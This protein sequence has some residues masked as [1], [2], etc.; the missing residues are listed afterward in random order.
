MTHT[1]DTVYT[2]YT[3]QKPLSTR[4]PHAIATSKVLFPVPNHLLTIN[5][6]FKVSNGCCLMGAYM[7][8]KHRN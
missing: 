5:W 1:L 7:E 8:Q 3:A 4:K 6:N 2:K